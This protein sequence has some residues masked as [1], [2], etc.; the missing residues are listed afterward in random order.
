MGMN[1][2]KSKKAE[3]IFV[4]MDVHK[5][6]F[7]LCCY[8]LENDAVW[9][10]A[11]IPADCKY[12]L[13]YLENAKASYDLNANIV[14][15]YEAGCLGY[16][17]QR[18]LKKHGVD[19]VIIAPSTIPVPQ[20]RKRIK[21][22]KRDAE[23]IA[24][25]L[26][27][28]TCRTV[29]IPS[30]Q[31]EEVKEYIRMRDAH[32]LHLKKTKQQ[33]K[34]F[35]LHQNIRYSDGRETWTIKYVSWLSKVELSPRNRETLDEYLITYHYFQERIERLDHRIEE[36]AQTEPYREN[37][38]M[39]CCF[40]GIKTITAMV[41]LCEI[42][43]FSRFYKAENFASFVGLVPGENSSGEK[44]QHLGITKAGNSHVR[45]V[46]IESAQCYNRSISLPKSKEL[47]KRQNGAAPEV[48]AYADKAR[49]RLKRKFN[50]ISKEMNKPANIACTAVARE[51][52]CFIWGMMTDHIS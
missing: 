37:V 2:T 27:F 50:R 40:T 18:T 46:L 14:C 15:G 44:Q 45:R 6:S 20:G 12:V 49:D 22:D 41:I 19:C 21:T 39:L 34:A 38:K 4:G 31:D 25:C 28:G 48:I 23:M 16:S 13:R 3:T 47:R 36:I 52:A 35:C 29:C 1:N 24:K 10:T 43:D 9:G 32:K 11:Q 33:I 8:T 42:G 51:L 17:L 30:V 5:E 26:A 7:T